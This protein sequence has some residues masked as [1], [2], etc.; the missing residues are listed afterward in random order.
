MGF[1]EINRGD[2]TAIELFVAGV[3]MWEACLQQ[4]TSRLADGK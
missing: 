4:F 1:R 3:G 2:K